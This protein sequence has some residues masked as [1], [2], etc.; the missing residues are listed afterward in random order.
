M[1]LWHHL[2]KSRVE[3][4]V[5]LQAWKGQLC[6]VLSDAKIILKASQLDPGFNLM[7]DE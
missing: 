4:N 7:G 5:I 3:T 6:C 1:P 2:R